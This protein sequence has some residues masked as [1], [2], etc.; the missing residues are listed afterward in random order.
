MV[1]WKNQGRKKEKCT[2]EPKKI[3]LFGINVHFRANFFVGVGFVLREVEIG[4]KGVYSAFHAGSE[5]VFFDLEF[6]MS[7]NVLSSQG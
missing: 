5:K 6:F 3:H 4:P 7:R 1:G 2:S